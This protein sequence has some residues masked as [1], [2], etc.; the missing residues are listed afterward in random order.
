M[1]EKDDDIVKDEVS[2]RS[3]SGAPTDAVLVGFEVVS[4]PGAG[5]EMIDAKLSPTL[6]VGLD[7]GGFS[8]KGAR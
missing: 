3:A 7:M 4:K 6:R 8:L 5:V 2:A 1:G